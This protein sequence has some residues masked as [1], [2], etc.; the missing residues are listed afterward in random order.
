MH[1]SCPLARRAGH[2][3]DDDGSGD[4]GDHADSDDVVACENAPSPQFRR[5]VVDDDVV[6]DLI[7]VDICTMAANLVS[8][9]S[10]VLSRGLA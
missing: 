7:E 9:W 6:G 1:L 4:G 10:A 3:V 2:D 8:C 5:S